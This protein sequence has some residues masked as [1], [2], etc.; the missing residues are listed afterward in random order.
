M[1]QPH[2]ERTN[3]LSP[4]LAVTAILGSGAAFAYVVIVALVPLG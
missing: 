3:V 4:I 2:P 1:S